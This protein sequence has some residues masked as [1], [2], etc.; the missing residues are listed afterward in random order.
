MRGIESEFRAL[1]ERGL[2]K[3][4]DHGVLL[5]SSEDFEGILDN[6]NIAKRIEEILTEYGITQI[7]WV[8]VQREPY[9]YFE[10]LYCEL[11]KNKGIV[12]GY[13][14][15]ADAIIKTGLFRVS[16]QHIS[17]A[18]V[19]DYHKFLATFQSS[20]RG[21]LCSC[22]MNQFIAD[23]FPGAML[24]DF[25]YT[26]TKNNKEAEKLNKQDLILTEEIASANQ[27]IEAND[28]ELNYALN[29]MD[30]ISQNNNSLAESYLQT[31]MHTMAAERLWE[32]TKAAPTVKT[33]FFERYGHHT[34]VEAGPVGWKSLINSYQPTPLE[35]ARA[36]AEVAKMQ[37]KAAKAE[38]QA[39]KA[40]AQARTLRARSKRLIKMLLGS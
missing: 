6:T 14:D 35:K 4:S 26:L 17:W 29:S 28:V 9:Q 5:I 2:A 27:R 18:F 1:V 22:T 11:S 15:M 21:T 31:W 12:I 19:F 3:I 25:C 38:A 37:A 30:S 16:V 40:E 10:S 24:L 13:R 33:L 34:T 32:K 23:T 20:I 36:D 8:V 39:A 7:Y